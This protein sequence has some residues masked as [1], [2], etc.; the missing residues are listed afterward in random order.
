MADDL[1]VNSWLV[2]PAGELRERFSRSSGPGGQSV[3]TTDSRVE[4]SFDVLR[5]P[6]LP[7][8]EREPSP[9]AARSP[10]GG[11]RD[12]RR[13]R[14]RAKPADEPRGGPGQAGRAAA[15]GDRPAP[16]AP[17]CHQADQGFPGA[18]AGRQAPP[19]PDQAQPPLRD[20]RRLPDRARAT[21]PTLP[22]GSSDSETEL[23]RQ[24]SSVG[25]P[26]RLASED[27]PEVRVAPRAPRLGADRAERP[28]LDERDRVASIAGRRRPPAAEWNA[29]S[30]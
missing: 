24:R 30:T 7:E 16:A 17:G 14:G 19:R 8:R 3:N 28:V 29:C 15:R 21:P 23:M 5:S 6:S 13:R 20:R 22:S 10:P 11:R 26:K 12:H 2:I 4:L 9:R 27:M 1:R 18:S 25:V